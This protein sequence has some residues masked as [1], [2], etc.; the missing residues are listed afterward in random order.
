MDGMLHLCT[1]FSPK[2]LRAG[3][4]PAI[5]QYHGRLTLNIGAARQPACQ[6]LKEKNRCRNAAVKTPILGERGGDTRDK[7][8]GAVEPGHWPA[9]LNRTVLID[10]D[11]HNR[12]E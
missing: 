6:A 12:C 1:H 7:L 5:W 4:A 3:M 10:E 8:S 9:S 11:H 2:I